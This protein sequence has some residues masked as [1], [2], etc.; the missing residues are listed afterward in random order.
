MK[1]VDLECKFKIR[2]GDLDNKPT[3]EEVRKYLAEAIVVDLDYENEGMAPESCGE[4]AATAIG[5]DLSTL[6][7]DNGD[8]SDNPSKFAVGICFDPEWRKVIEGDNVDYVLE[9]VIEEG[10]AKNKIEAA[11][12]IRN[13]ISMVE[14]GSLKEL[15]AYVQGIDDAIGWMECSMVDEKFILDLENLEINEPKG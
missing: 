4:D 3:L 14:F 6:T 9:S 8:K 2:I 11:K 13:K 10:M 7:W 1:P 12:E 15:N 5:V